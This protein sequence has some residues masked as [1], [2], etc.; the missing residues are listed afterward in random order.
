MKIAYDVLDR[1]SLDYCI[2]DLWEQ[3]PT[4]CSDRE[5]QREKLFPGRSVTRGS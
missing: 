2:F 4:E 3:P 5:V 1:S